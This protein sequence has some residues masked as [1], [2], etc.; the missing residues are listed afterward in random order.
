[1]SIAWTVHGRPRFS[2]AILVI[3]ASFIRNTTQL[4]LSFSFN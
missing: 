1:M 3:N 2:A 4:I